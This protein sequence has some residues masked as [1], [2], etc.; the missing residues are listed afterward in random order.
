MFAPNQGRSKVNLRYGRSKNL[1]PSNKNYFTKIYWYDFPW[2]LNLKIGQWTN[3]CHFYYYYQGISIFLYQWF[4]NYWL[5]LIFLHSLKYGALGNRLYRHGLAT[6]LLPTQWRE[7]TYS[8]QNQTVNDFIPPSY[9]NSF[10]TACRRNLAGDVCAIMRVH[11]FLEQWGLINYQVKNVQNKQV[12]IQGVLD[13]RRFNI[14]HF[15]F[16]SLSI[17]HRSSIYAI[18]KFG[19]TSFFIMSSISVLFDAYRGLQK[20]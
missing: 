8:S 12:I 17:R 20:M 18:P 4:S 19:I 13:K 10:S 15:S 11:A 1:L 9:S 7:V 6:A 14:R 3:K 2:E 16:T 5:K